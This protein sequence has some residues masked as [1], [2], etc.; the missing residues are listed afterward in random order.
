M[1]CSIKARLLEVKHSSAVDTGHHMKLPAARALWYH[2][3]LDSPSGRAACW[4]S[5][6]HD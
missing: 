4:F 3:A 1:L 6:R 5:I 2:C